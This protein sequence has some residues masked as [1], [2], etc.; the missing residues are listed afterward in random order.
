MKTAFAAAA[1]LVAAVA[2]SCASGSGSER[3][4]SALRLNVF[5]RGLSEPVY[6]TSPRS[7]PGRVYVVEKC[8]RIRVF[9]N[10]RR[11]A[12]PF[13][14]IR[15]LV[16]CGGSEQGLFAV[17][18][19]PGY[20]RNHRFF[21]HYTDRRGD[22]RV[23]EYRSNGSAAIPSTRRELLFVD[24][25]YANHNG[26]EI[27]FGP[28]GLL[29][30]GLGDG[31]GGGDPENRA[32]NLRSKLGKLLRLNVDRRGAGWQIAAYGLRNPW[33]FAFDRAN[34][35]LYI[36]DVGESA[37]EEID[38]RSRARLARVANYGW[39][40]YEGRARHDTSRRLR[41]GGQLVMPVAV[42]SHRFGCSVTG[43]YV[44]R[45]RA[46]SSARG[47]YFYGDYCTGIIWSLRMSG[48]RA[49]VRRERIH[50]DELSS[51]GEDARGELYAI[52]LGGTIYRL[53]G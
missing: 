35:N 33:R 10:G 29:Y 20:T 15:N 31:G 16:G 39:S 49:S 17:A 3:S 44:Y 27:T 11:L 21:V 13:L 42:Y 22:T 43:G 12:Q 7:Q 37:F 26:G 45:G 23:A 6:L 5:A 48:G 9:V 2:V 34:G 40:V 36:A 50:V 8:G 4:A 41:G 46:V 25:P 32:Q 30:L 1:V 38:F 53:R 52:S 14:D 51:F 24:Q 19:H 28:D 18:F 47:R